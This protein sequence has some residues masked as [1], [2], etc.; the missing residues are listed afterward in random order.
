MI[1]HCVENIRFNLVIKEKM[2]EKEHYSP[3]DFSAGRV[4]LA[5]VFWGYGII[6]FF[7]VA[8]LGNWFI[9]A[10]K[11]KQTAI[12]I[13]LAVSF[14]Y[15][16]VWIVAAWRSSGNYSGFSF[17]RFLIRVVLVVIVLY[18]IFLAARF[19]FYMSR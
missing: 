9:G 6:G 16:V 11:N 13:A 15:S 17:W 18:W 19:A 1:R 5:R 3:T 2:E 14:F 7:I 10:M 8:V 4:P 12:V